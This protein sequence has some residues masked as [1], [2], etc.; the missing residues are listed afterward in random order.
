[1]IP[2]G[3][4]SREHHLGDDADHQTKERLTQKVQHASS[5]SRHSP[6]VRRQR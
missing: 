5:L 4:E 1:M 2:P 3:S 6:R